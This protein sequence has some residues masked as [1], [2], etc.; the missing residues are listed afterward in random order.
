MKKK[1]SQNPDCQPGI[2]SE[3]NQN[4]FSAKLQRP[5]IEDK[6]AG[7]RA[8]I[9][10]SGSFASNASARAGSNSLERMPAPE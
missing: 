9:E 1:F 10:R 8:R 6:H 2:I 3:A 7:P 4:A 5:D